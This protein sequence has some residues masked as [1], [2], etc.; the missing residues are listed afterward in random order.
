MRVRE[1]QEE[2]RLS[3]EAEQLCLLGAVYADSGGR[4][5]QH[6]ALVYEWV[7]NTDDVALVLSTAEFFERRGT[8]LSGSFVSLETLASD[9]EAGK[10]KEAWST[11]IIRN[12]LPKTTVTFKPR[13][14]LIAQ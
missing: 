10:L 2:L 4:T 12:L 3:V 7:A 5:S 11:E 1:L 8:S 6:M 9:V 13:L 14:I